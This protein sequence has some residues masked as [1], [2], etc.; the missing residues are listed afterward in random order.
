MINPRSS[1]DP[2]IKAALEAWDKASRSHEQAFSDAMQIRTALHNAASH[3]AYGWA[4]MTCGRIAAYREQLDLAEV[5]L[6]EAL[7]R[8]IFVG[9]KYG[10]GIAMSHLA[11]PEVFHRNLD[12]ALELALK[13]LSSGVAY[14]DYDADLLYNI[15][16]Q[17]YWARDEYHPAILYLT[18]AYDLVRNTTSYHRRSVIIGNIG[19]VLVEL[20]ENDLG[21][22]AST[23]AWRLQLDHC[24][25]RTELRLTPLANMVRANCELNDYVA[26]LRHAEL[27]FKYLVS[28]T[29]PSS[30]FMFE[31]LC[32]AFSLN[33]HIEKAEYCLHQSRI[34][35]QDNPAPDSS[36]MMQIGQATLLE[37]RKDYN[38][39]IA[40]AK[41]VLDVPVASVT[42]GAHRVAA[43]LL[44]RSYAALG[45]SAESAKWKQFAAE[46]GREK[47]L[48]DILSSQVRTSLKVEQPVE[49]LTARELACLSLSA[50]GQTSADIALKLDIKTRTVNY[51]FTQILRKLNAMNRQE[52]IAKAS[53]A[54][55]LR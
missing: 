10:E 34:L 39:A 9:D 55:L 21:L 4:A 46:T 17:C 43:M 32:E 33:G 42:H 26:A 49:P 45:R 23:E 38:T 27:L 50:H 20:G 30:W 47:L 29:I 15:A 6:T 18:K 35:T 5:L 22:A 53:A 19:A 37:A 14:S 41:K 7:G 48:S 24:Q 51:H 28:T 52:A 36:A 1:N 40:L 8:F 12:H 25:D 11:I 44:S 16:A 2:E 54:N 31:Y 13:P 3:Q